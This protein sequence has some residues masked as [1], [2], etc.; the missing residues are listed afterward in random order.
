MLKKKPVW[1]TVRWLNIQ[2]QEIPDRIK[3]I[4]EKEL[5][6]CNIR[7]FPGSSQKLPPTPC[8]LPNH[9]DDNAI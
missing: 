6:G 2:A 8:G 9:P 1:L 3:P 7:P 5:A 4:F